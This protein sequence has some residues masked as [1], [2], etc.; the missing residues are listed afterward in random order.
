[1][2]SGVQYVG[3]ASPLGYTDLLLPKISLVPIL[4]NNYANK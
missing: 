2:K 1:M 3:F 4:L